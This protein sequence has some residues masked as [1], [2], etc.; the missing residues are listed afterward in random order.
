MKVEVIGKKSGEFTDKTTGERISF[1]K[2]HCIGKFDISESGT[3]GKQCM[4][5]SCA[6]RNLED[7]PIPCTADIQFNQYGRLASVEVIAFEEGV[8]L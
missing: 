8:E 4:I 1:G 3:T 7:I 2:L 5:I 6:P